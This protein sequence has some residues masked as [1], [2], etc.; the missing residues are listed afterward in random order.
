MSKNK[1]TKGIPSLSSLTS[2]KKKDEEAMDAFVMGPSESSPNLPIPAPQASTQPQMVTQPPAPSANV[3]LMTESEYYCTLGWKDNRRT[4]QLDEGLDNWVNTWHAAMVKNYKRSED[5][6]PTKM[7]IYHYALF[8]LRQAYQDEVQRES[9]EEWMLRRRQL[10][11][12]E[13]YAQSAN[14]LSK[15][16]RAQEAEKRRRRAEGNSDS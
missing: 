15:T 9:A 10:I 3:V 12:E 6:A 1:K 7:D 2:Q 13:R 8:K 14:S 4:L 11:E 16:R 5:K